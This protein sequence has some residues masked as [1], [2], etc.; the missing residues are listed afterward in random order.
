MFQTFATATEFTPRI[1]TQGDFLLTYA[2]VSEN[3]PPARGTFALHVDRDLEKIRF[4]MVRRERE[5][6]TDVRT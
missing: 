3:F 1:P 2:V 5:C 4:T 6:N